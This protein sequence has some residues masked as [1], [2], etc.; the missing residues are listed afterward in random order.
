MEV[1]DSY[2]ECFHSRHYIYHIL[3]QTT[4]AQFGMHGLHKSHVV[5]TVDIADHMI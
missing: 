5:C 3:S 1:Y 4:Y 2:P